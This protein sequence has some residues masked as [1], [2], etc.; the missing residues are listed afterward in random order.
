MDTTRIV[1]H[2]ELCPALKLAVSLE[3]EFA[4]VTHAELLLMPGG[5]SR[6]I[7]RAA[8]SEARP[9]CM[10]ERKLRLASEESK[11]PS[12]GLGRTSAVRSRKQP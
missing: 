11:N 2:D 9:G 10:G 4:Q 3:C 5:S 6:R 7:G 8:P 1:I 12:G